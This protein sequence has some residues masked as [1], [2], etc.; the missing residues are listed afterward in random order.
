MRKV[1]VVL[2]G[3]LG[4]SA[5]A[6]ACSS[7]SSQTGGGGDTSDASTPLGDASFSPDSGLD[8]AVVG[9]TTP[10]SVG[11]TPATPGVSV[12]QGATAQLAISLTRNSF[13]GALT[14]TVTGLPAGVTVAPVAIAP[15]G[16]SASITFAAAANAALGTAPVTLHVANADGKVSS[17]TPI[18]LS[19]RGVPG[20]LDASFGTA[21][22]VSAPDLGP[23]AGGVA[24][25]STGGIVVTSVILDP[26]TGMTNGDKDLITARF[27]VDGK[28]DT[29]FGT[30]GKQVLV[31]GGFSDPSVYQLTGVPLIAAAADDSLVVLP[32]ALHGNQINPHTPAYHLSKQGVFDSTW[33]DGTGFLDVGTIS[34]AG[35]AV[36]PNI[37]VV[38][39]YGLGNGKP[40]V[41]RFA[42]AKGVLDGA[43]G[44][45]FYASTEQANAVS[46]IAT[47]GLYA[48]GD[49][50]SP[51]FL[52]GGPASGTAFVA[53]IAANG[54][55]DTNFGAS[56][57]LANNG[58][59]TCKGIVT[60]KQGDALVLGT[61]FGTRLLLEHVTSAGFDSLYRFP[62]SPAPTFGSLKSK[63]VALA[64][65]D[66]RPIMLGAGTV[67]SVP[68]LLLARSNSD[69]SL[70]ASFGTGGYVNTTLGAA[71][72][73][74]AVPVAMAIQ[75]D[76]KVVVV[77]SLDGALMIA[78][79]WL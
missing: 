21:G 37:V 63:A 31:T 2:W 3:A 70:D 23:A 35:L 9:P 68:V 20:T 19:V 54:S 10:G 25:Q 33:G 49:Y 13:S 75:P 5:V 8:A 64:L 12:V 58:A 17:T 71:T 57:V 48:C 53:R 4:V 38:G 39:V 22:V 73:A 60:T 74:G 11:I 1:K 29:T 46:A 42:Y 56:G 69:G 43:F 76:G 51:T 41:Q 62:A 18:A 77:G 55:L 32:N 30:A 59:D 52:D 40:S 24:L 61:V 66:D 27:T 44:G 45:N 36:G 26:V 28:L 6:V 50:E 16:T 15:G 78:R 14:A 47:G 72:A 67:A 34:S 7:G 79:F 65:Q